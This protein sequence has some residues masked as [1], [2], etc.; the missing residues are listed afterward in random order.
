MYPPSGRDTPPAGGAGAVVAITNHTMKTR[1]ETP[2]G[3]HDSCSPQNSERVTQNGPVGP[4]NSERATQ[5]A[6]TPAGG[7]RSANAERQDAPSGRILAGIPCLNTAAHIVDV[8]TATLPYVDEVVVVDDGSTDNTAELARKAGA[9][10]LTHPH[11]MGVGAALRTL[12]D[13]A[14]AHDAAALVTLDGDGQH[15]PEDIPGLLAPVLEGRSSM[16]LGSRFLKV[17]GPSRVISMPRYRAFGIRVIT[18]L[19]NM[20][21]GC[22]LT[23]SQC[24]LRAYGPSALSALAPRSDGFEWSIEMPVNARALGMRMVEVPVGCIYHADGSTMHP[25][26]Q[27]VRLAVAVLR[28]RAR[29]VMNRW[30]GRTPQRSASPASVSCTRGTEDA[31]PPQGRVR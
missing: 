19:F 5:N 8:V 14:T 20:A 21:S 1:C 28:L 31:C 12:F 22:R 9:T 17:D 13:Y 26:L 27:G 29:A 16:V 11:N 6:D 15:L 24:G 18:F 23:D 25:V 10:V 30:S 3:R 7:L 4:Q 2:A